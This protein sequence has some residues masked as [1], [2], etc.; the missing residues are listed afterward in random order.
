MSG[1]F[2][3][4]IRRLAG[5]I[6]E[7]SVYILWKGNIVGTLTRRM[8]DACEE[9]YV[10]RIDWEAWDRLQPK[11]EIAGL[12]MQLRK[13]EY[14]RPFTPAFMTDFMPPPGRAD[15]PDLMKQYGLTGKYDMWD[16]MCAQGRV[17]R[18]TFTVKRVE[19]YDREQNASK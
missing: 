1:G 9:E 3:M 5:D 13:E 4:E 2:Y 8:N 18:D 17:C 6:T 7:E 11:D 19:E 10:F 15:I 16:F 14:I 12:N